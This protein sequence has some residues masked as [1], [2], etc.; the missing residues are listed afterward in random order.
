MPKYRIV[1]EIPSSV[2]VFVEAETEDEAKDI[3]TSIGE[4]QLGEIGDIVD[5]ERLDKE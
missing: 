2:A 5:V 4:H 1:F 3:A